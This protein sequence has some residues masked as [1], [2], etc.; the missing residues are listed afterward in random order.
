MAYLLY[1]YTV[2]L[3]LE[4]FLAIAVWISVI[5]MILVTV[6]IFIEMHFQDLTVTSQKLAPLKKTT[7]IYM[8][9]LLSAVTF[10]ALVPSKSDM[11]F[12]LGG[13]AVYEVASM[14]E[15]KE[16]PENLINAAN[17]FLESVSESKDSKLDSN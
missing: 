10:I 6:A 2:M 14:D 8:A 7:K 13:W 3:S 15:A 1:L 12:I 4:V 9:F 16:L 17:T 11:G 5:V